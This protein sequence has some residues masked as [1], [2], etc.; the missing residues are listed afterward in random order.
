MHSQPH[1]QPHTAK[2]CAEE[3]KRKKCSQQRLR[4]KRRRRHRAQNNCFAFAST[5]LVCCCRG[6]VFLLSFSVFHSSVG[7]FFS[8]LSRCR[9]SH[10]FF[11]A[12]PSLLVFAR[13]KFVLG[14]LFTSRQT[15][16]KTHTKIEFRDRLS[17]DKNLL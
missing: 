1:S 4:T 7:G 6:C 12:L 17:R 14:A 8:F 2:H 15:K 5:C 10:V 11:I 13:Y 16:Q 3:A 9:R